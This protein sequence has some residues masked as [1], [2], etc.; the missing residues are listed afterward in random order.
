MLE[1]MPLIVALPC[2]SASKFNLKRSELTSA[3]P[4][5]DFP[6]M[7]HP[8]RSSLNMMTEILATEQRSTNSTYAGG[9]FNETN[10][11]RKY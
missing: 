11:V 3:A 6:W 9:N 8:F 1:W 4:H 5:G 7:Y 2:V 10:K